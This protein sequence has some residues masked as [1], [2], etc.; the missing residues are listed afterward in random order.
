MKLGALLSQPATWSELIDTVRLLERV[1]Y[2]ELWFGDHLYAVF[3]D[4]Y[5]PIFE[6]WT[7]LT[8]WAFVTQRARLGLLVG[9]NTFRH[10]ALVAK[11]V[12]TLD[13]AS[14]GRAILGLGG[15]WFEFEHRAF[16]IPFGRTPGER[17]GW[18]DEAA[19]VIRDLLDGEAVTFHSERYEL[20]AAR[21][22]PLPVQRRLPIMIGGTGERKTLRTVAK[23]AD[24]W[25]TAGPPAT[26]RHQD[27]VLRAHCAAV[28]RDPASIE[29]TV[30]LRPI[31]RDAAEDALRVW[32]DQLARK[33]VPPEREHWFSGGTPSQLA[34][35]VEQCA[36]VGFETVIAELISPYDVETIERLATEV[37]PLAEARTTSPRPISTSSQRGLQIDKGASS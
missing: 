26:L 29:R 20:D 36:E 24:M 15:G 18:L 3:G 30:R 17:L 12:T 2:D 6:A 23:Y 25:N 27:E 22:S 10:P 7:T 21:I 13:H 32:T 9:A 14:G 11:M 1:G 35:L 8:A 5:H 16:G 34:T 4:P 31:V 19:G 37:R 28:G 33:K